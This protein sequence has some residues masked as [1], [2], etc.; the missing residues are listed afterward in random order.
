MGRSHWLR[1]TDLDR[2]LARAHRDRRDA[3]STLRGRRD[4]PRTAPAQSRPRG[5][6]HLMTRSPTA[7]ELERV[8]VHHVAAVDRCIR[9]SARVG[10]GA[11]RI[12][13]HG[14]CS[15]GPV[16]GDRST[17]PQPSL[18][19]CQ[20]ATALGHFPH[21]GP[22]G[23]YAASFSHDLGNRATPLHARPRRR[24]PKPLLLGEGRISADQ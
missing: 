3:L 21:S 18:V 9:R 20:L 22:R 4:H 19:G 10:R 1:T 5:A 14:I 16:R 15:A 6:R 2:M 12:A 24:F 23:G 11:Q 17:T 13:R 7:A 8:H